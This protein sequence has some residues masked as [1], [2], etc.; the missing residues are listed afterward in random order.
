MN[1]P[2]APA[3]DAA[4]SSSAQDRLDDATASLPPVSYA[5]ATDR[6]PA[7]AATEVDAE[8]APRPTP[9]RWF[10]PSRAEAVTGGWVPAGPA[11]TAPAS[12][13]GGRGCR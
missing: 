9:E 3:P 8:Q 7:W 5:P 12:R 1:D 4:E 2:F 11:A 13:G 6:R 10:E